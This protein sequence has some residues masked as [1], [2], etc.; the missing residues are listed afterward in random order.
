VGTKPQP[1][2]LASVSPGRAC[3]LPV[4]G[5]FH[6]GRKRSKH[7]LPEPLARSG[8]DGMLVDQGDFAG[9]TG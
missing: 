7:V 6:C 2:A 5:H 8:L 9:R 3:N 4:I 1:S